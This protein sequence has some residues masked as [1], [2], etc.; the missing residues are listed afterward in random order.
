MMEQAEHGYRVE[1]RKVHLRDL[2]HIRKDEAA[3]IAESLLRLADIAF[4]A[5]DPRVIDIAQKLPQGA[6]TAADIEKTA[7]LQGA[8]IGRDDEFDGAFF[9][10]HPL[11]TAID[12]WQGEGTVQR[13]PSFSHDTSSIPDRDSRSRRAFAGSAGA[14]PRNR[15]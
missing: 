5:V 12:P 6:W 1:R 8:E 13:V 7:A 3:A 9:A 14:P 15:V 10:Q 4:V 2:P 11:Q